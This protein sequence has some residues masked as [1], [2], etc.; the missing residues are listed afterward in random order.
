MGKFECVMM[1][2]KGIPVGQYLQT[3]E[4]RKEGNLWENHRISASHRTWSVTKWVGG[5]RQIYLCPRVWPRTYWVF[6]R[7]WK[8]QLRF[9]FCFFY[10]WYHLSN[11]REINMAIVFGMAWVFESYWRIGKLLYKSMW[12]RKYESG[13][14]QGSGERSSDFV[15]P[16]TE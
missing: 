12:H 9:W 14:C 4:S 16:Q 3:S 2:K 10:G 15:T 6:S 5:Q 7:W 1:K 11:H 13:R 8:T